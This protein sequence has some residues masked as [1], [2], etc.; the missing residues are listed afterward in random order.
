MSNHLASAVLRRYVDE[1]EI[2]LSYEKEHLLQCG[3]CRAAFETIREQARDAERILARDCS[4]PNLK[5]ARAEIARR[6]ASLR[7]PLET[8]PRS[9]RFVDVR[10]LIGAAAAVAVVLLFSYAPFRAYA[11][12]FLTIFEPHTLAPISLT[13][14]DVRSLQDI[15]Q[16]REIGRV[17]TSKRVHSHRFA[18]LA[19]AE[20]FARV[21]IAHPGYLPASLPR[22]EAYLVT[23]PSTVRFTFDA[24]KARASAARKHLVIPPAPA[25]VDGATLSAT[26]GPLVVEFYGALPSKGHEHPDR[27]GFPQNQVIVA[28][29]PVPAVHATSGDMHAVESYLLSLPNVP[30]DVKEQIRAIEDPQGT[31]PVPVS[32][33][34]NTARRITVNGSPGL[35]IGDDTGIGAVVV[36]LSHGIFYSVAGGFTADDVSKIAASMGT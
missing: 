23:P 3:A 36:W 19:A 30:A 18:S 4:S 20:R 29:A 33:D 22:V 28:Q 7:E 12:N 10:R 1:P 17:S 26:T 27:D 16:L 6:A 25:G 35:L 2:L 9:A 8:A 5:Q 21:P 34:K 15:P 32:V 11:E 31:L 24:R 14:A 13:A